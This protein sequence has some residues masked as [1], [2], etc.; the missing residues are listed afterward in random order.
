MIERHGWI[1]TTMIHREKARGW[2]A[3]HN[4]LI[5]YFQTPSILSKYRNDTL[6]IGN[7][8]WLSLWR[9]YWK[10]WCQFYTYLFNF[11][12]YSHQRF[13]NK[14]LQLEFNFG[15]SKKINSKIQVEISRILTSVT[16]T[17]GHHNFFNFSCLK[18]KELFTKKES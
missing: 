2:M 3:A 18:N 17:L 10:T 13:E 12:Y 7:H 15:Q 11:F 6:L 4:V 14:F 8:V 5:Y 16:V 1:E 9:I